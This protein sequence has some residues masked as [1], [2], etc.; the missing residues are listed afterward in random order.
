MKLEIYEPVQHLQPYDTATDCSMR[1]SPWVAASSSAGQKITAFHVNQRFI[2]FLTT[3]CNFSPSCARWVHST[4]SHFIYLK[5]IL[6][7]HLRLGLPVTSLLQ[8]SPP[9][10]VYEYL[11]SSYV[12][13]APPISFSLPTNI[14]LLPLT[15]PVNKPQSQC[16]SVSPDDTAI[17]LHVS[18]AIQNQGDPPAGS[19]AVPSYESDN[20][21]SVPGR[22]YS[23]FCPPNCLDR[24][25]AHLVPYTVGTGVLFD[26]R[27]LHQ[28]GVQLTVC[29]WCGVTI[30]QSVWC[31]GATCC[32]LE[33]V[34]FWCSTRGL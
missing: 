30:E 17:L 7:C 15:T 14:Q 13:H 10:R 11:F 8:F 4:T 32:T 21:G 9:S 20:P 3:G 31:A 23:V 28:L 27:E 2:P 18:A 5:Y 25:W 19:T 24:S 12:L 34:W 26:R 22:G 1:R 16:T 6:Y 33:T 29:I